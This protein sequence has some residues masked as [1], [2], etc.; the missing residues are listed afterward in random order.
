MGRPCCAV[1]AERDGPDNGPCHQG[2]HVLTSVTQSAPVQH[3]AVAT[4]TKGGKPVW[5]DV[6]IL[7]VPDARPDTLA[8]VQLFRDVTTAKEIEA[9]VRER[10]LQAQLSA[11]PDDAAPLELTRREH[12]ILRL[13]ANGA[14][15]RT[16]ADQL[17]VSPITVR[18]HV[19]NILRKLN[20]HSRLEA[21]AY[22]TRHRLL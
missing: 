10:F 9:L 3:R 2:C 16:M 8:I 13:I 7:A 6:S 5:L 22:A 17:R 12:E 14:G 4:R 21:M 11:P 20:V 19:Q 1:F 18:N 15:T